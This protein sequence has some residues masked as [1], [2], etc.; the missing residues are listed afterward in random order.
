MRYAPFLVR[1]LERIAFLI[2]FLTLFFFANGQNA[3]ADVGTIIATSTVSIS[4]CNNGIVDSGEVC[5]FGL[6]FN[7][8]AYSSTSAGRHC[9]TN[10]RSWGPY[11]G[12]GVL[13]AYYGEQ[14][15]PDGNN[16]CTDSCQQKEPPISS[17][18]PPQPPP[19]PSGN[20]G[21]SGA[22][23]MRAQT[24][25]VFAGKAYPN[26]SVQVLKD[27]QLLVIAQA[28]GN[29]DFTY[30]VSNATPGPTTFGFWSEDAKK[31]RS[32]TYTTTFQ[33]TQNAVTNVNNVFLPPTIR[34]LLPK[35]SPGSDIVLDGT[36]APRSYV[37]LLVD[38]SSA[39]VQ[40]ATSR[41]NGEWDT[42]LSTVGMTPEIFHQIL[43]YLE[44]PAASGTIPQKSG[45]GTSLNIFVGNSNVADQTSN[46]D[47]NGDGKVNMI[48]FSMLLFR[49]GTAGPVGDLNHDGKVNIA[50]LS[51]M[52]FNW[53]S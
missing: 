17:S 22:V 34:A 12:D 10:C 36:T 15:V 44:L 5:D 4:I 7:D 32:I 2:L 43:P 35:V 38:K 3:S 13:K 11:C 50:D 41:D 20:G 40:M 25:V 27:G 23:P 48:D 28:D 45:N 47:I 46:G 49:F 1:K 19:T 6:G 39:P 16:F 9:A 51:I 30:N 33:V 31:I 21:G 53:T 18:T 14:C 42:K 29:A 26:S 24:Q 8:G 37:Q 52:L